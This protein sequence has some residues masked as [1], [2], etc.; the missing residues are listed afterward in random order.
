MNKSYSEL[1]TFFRMLV[2]HQTDISWVKRNLHFF[3]DI[4]PETVVILIDAM[5]Q[6]NY[7]I[8][9]LKTGV[10]KFLNLS[11]KALNKELLPVFNENSVFHWLLKS[12]HLLLQ[13]ID[14]LRPLIKEIQTLTTHELIQKIKERFSELMGLDQHYKIIENVI[15]PI[16][17]LNI[18]SFRCVM[19]MWS[20]H[21]DIRRNLKS[22]LELLNPEQFDLKAFNRLCGDLFFD[23]HAIKFR[24][25]K[26]LYPLII[27]YLSDIEQNKLLREASEIGFAFIN[28]SVI[29]SENNS[30][31]VKENQRYDQGH[32]DLTT[33]L[34]TADHV[35]LI[36]NHLP[37]DITFVDEH[38]TVRYFSTPSHRVFTRT[39][40][41]IGRQVQNCHPPESIQ[42][43]NEIIEAF[44][45]G[46]KDTAEFWINIKNRLFLIRY[47]AVRNEQNRYLGILEVTQDISEIKN[48]NGERRLLDW[49]D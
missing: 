36:F 35:R 8:E 37:V 42:V 43:V 12:N 22:I 26:I 41:I 16:F 44:K 19:V 2:N 49:N 14:S 28:Q 33:G 20:F 46:R 38:D 32:I 6:E 18:S 47:F 1:T 5:Y 25:E 27:N 34:L 30:G 48:L 17:E 7:P 24:E 10:N 3:D 4:T 40:S 9:D 15:F 45:S 39:K 31:V 29:S 11:Y 23:I 13:I 21:D